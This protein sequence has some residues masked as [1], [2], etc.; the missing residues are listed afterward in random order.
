[1]STKKGYIFGVLIALFGSAVLLVVWNVFTRTM[2]ISH[3][4]IVLGAFLLS[5]CLALG[6]FGASLPKEDIRHGALIMGAVP[7]ALAGIG[8]L[9]FGITPAEVQQTEDWAPMLLGL[10]SF[11]SFQILLVY[12]FLKVRRRQT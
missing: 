3:S 12:L 5:S 7:G 2:T 10:A 9:F 1:M 4:F 6:L 11:I 8:C